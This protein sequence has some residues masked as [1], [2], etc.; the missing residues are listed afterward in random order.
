MAVLTT[1]LTG[2]NHQSS[3]FLRVMDGPRFVKIKQGKKTTKTSLLR[4]VKVAL[5]TSWYFGWARTKPMRPIDRKSSKG[6]T[7]LA[8]FTFRVPCNEVKT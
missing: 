8:K 5:G 7:A 1:T 3:K 2:M 4:N 6:T